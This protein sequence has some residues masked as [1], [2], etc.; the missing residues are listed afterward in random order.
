MI[1]FIQDYF[2]NQMPMIQKPAIWYGIAK[3]ITHVWWS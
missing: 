3:T 1:L 2:D